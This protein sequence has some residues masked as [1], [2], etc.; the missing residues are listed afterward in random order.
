MLVDG[1]G[2]FDLDARDFGRTRLLPTLLDRGVTRLDAVL[3]THPHPDHVLGLFAV[4]EELDVE[5][6]WRS[7]GQDENDLYA[8]LEAAAAA[9][10]IPVRPLESF[11]VWERDGAR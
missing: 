7:S 4:L 10:R 5:A 8:R 9:R 6:L 11:D 3:A 1:G 2:P